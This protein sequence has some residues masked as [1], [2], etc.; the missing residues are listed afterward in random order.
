MSELAEVIRREAPSLGFQRVGFAPARPED[1]HRAALER[2]LEA[3][4]HAGMAFMDETRAVRLD[5]RRLL[6]GARS[7]IMVA[8]YY[9]PPPPVEGPRISAYAAGPDYHASMK[10]S[11]HDLCA[12]IREH[13]P[14]AQLLPFV[15]THPVLERARRRRTG[16]RG[17]NTMLIHPRDGSFF[18]LGGILT[19]LELP[20]GTPLTENCGTCH[21]CLDACPTS[22]FPEPF[23]V[24]SARCIGYL[25]VE[26]R[27]RFTN[28][29]RAMIGEWVFGCDVCQTV[30]PFNHKPMQ[31][32]GEAGNVQV[33]VRK[34]LQELTQQP[35]NRLHGD[36]AISRA[37]R[38]GMIRNLLVVAENL[39]DKSILDV[40]PL[41][42]D[43]RDKVVVDMAEATR[44]RLV[45]E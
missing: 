21:A 31:R 39:H 14:D 40:L 25:T 30:C 38:R 36:S 37:R 32:A 20:L 27:G 10:E 43:D 5:P 29:Q 42:A 13:A 12:T 33:D 45:E 19:D 23:V 7:A 15:D 1:L 8:R 9:P 2:W 26:H 22:A 3:G 6:P 34:M 28:K 11:L 41:F 35:F 24:D 44:R 4:R 18:F 17:Q 16:L